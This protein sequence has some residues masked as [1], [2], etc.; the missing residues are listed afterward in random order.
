MALTKVSRGLLTTSIVDNGNAT[1]ITIDSNENVGIGT[2]SPWETA[3]IPFNSKLSFGS[4]AYP[5][6][7]SR[8]A[9]GTLNTTIED[10]YD[11]SNTR[12]DFKMRAGS[13]NE[14]IPLSLTSAGNVGINNP[15]PAQTLSICNPANPN[16]NGMEI[17]IGAGDTS[18]NTIQN[19]NRAT[20]AYTPL[21]IAAS[22][23]TFGVGTSATERLRIDA[24]GSISIPNQNA[25]NEL[26]FTGS[27]FTNV[28]SA[29]T[30]GFQFGTTGAGYLA[31][32]TNNAEQARIDNSGR[33][34]VNTTSPL[35]GSA[36][37]LQA[38][39]DV[40]DEWSTRINNTSASPY[41]LIVEYSSAAP[42]GGINYFFYANDQ[43]TLRF[44]VNSNG[45]IRNF[46]A[47]NVNLSDRNAKKDITLHTD[48]EWNCVKAW[49]IVDYRYKD[50]AD[51]SPAKIGVTAQQIQEHC[52]DLVTV[53]QEQADA[54]EEVI[55]EDGEVVTEAKAAV[56][57][58]IGVNE[59]QMMWKVTK[60]LQ[61]AMERIETLEAK[62]QTLENN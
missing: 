46:S 57:E 21:N 38:L 14:V 32:L 33:L 26:T 47:N 2:S 25:I 1:A 39:Q 12:L 5:L 60:A 8:S 37:K 40:T 16:R 62:V 7:I 52:P 19:Y 31:F 58:R 23:L 49:E 42:N 34:L 61:E 50:E 36:A 53:F 29:T 20:A 59:S 35:I 48:S 11:I 17:A 3:S 56:E 10:G 4:S 9:A 44:A 6:S 13:A 54:V 43:T 41:G 55:G 18:S 30:S 15:N 51:D 28:V 24:N 27:E 22:F 45:G